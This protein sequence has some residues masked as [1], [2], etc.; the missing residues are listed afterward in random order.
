MLPA[1]G[2]AAAALGLGGCSLALSG[3]SPDRPR[4]RHPDCD[5][6]KGLIVLDGI[7]GS[8][9]GLGSL[10]ALG[11]NASAVALLPAAL[12]AVFLGS[13]IAANRRVNACRAA[14]AEYEDGQRAA[15]LPPPALPAPA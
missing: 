12:G 2:F 9:L 11:D 8:S 15:P 14:F 10:V 13:A 5:T 3:P 1:L 6:G 4:D 7:V